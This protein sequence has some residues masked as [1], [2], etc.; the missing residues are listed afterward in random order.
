MILLVNSDIYVHCDEYYIIPV[1]GCILMCLL[2]RHFVMYFYQSK[3]SRANNF[4]DTIFIGLHINR[5]HVNNIAFW[6]D[7]VRYMYHGDSVRYGEIQ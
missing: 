6:G 3:L 4:S 5:H 2:V 1:H 7:T